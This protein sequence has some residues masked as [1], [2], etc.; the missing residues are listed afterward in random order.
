MCCVVFGTVCSAESYT[1]NYPKWCPVSGG[2]WFE[3]D[4]AQGKACVVVPLNSRFDVFGFS[5]TTGYNVCNITNSTVSGNIYFQSATSYYGEPTALQC[6]FQSY[7]TLQLYVPYQNNY[8][9]TSYQWQN[10]DVTDIHNTNVALS[11]EAADRQ[12]NAYVFTT[13]E[14]LLMFVCVLLIGILLYYIL[15]RSWRA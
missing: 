4:T 1:E 6:R 9:G 13:T 12:N 5:G 2:A 7:G 11:D 15:G 14:K 10:L 8:G 3:V